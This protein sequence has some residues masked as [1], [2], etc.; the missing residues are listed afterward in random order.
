MTLS[1]EFRSVWPGGSHAGDRPQ[2]RHVLTQKSNTSYDS[3]VLRR[4]VVCEDSRQV[5]LDGLTTIQLAAVESD[6]MAIRI[7]QSSD[8]LRISLVPLRQ[9]VGVERPYGSIVSRRRPYRL[10]VFKPGFHEVAFLNLQSDT[11]AAK[12]AM[13]AM[14][15]MKK[16]DIARIEAAR[17]E[18][19]HAGRSA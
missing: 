17:A 11:A 4:S 13:D 3:E 15:T 1:A 19:V 10:W 18:D 2:Q 5:R 7:E 12:R 14:M 9:D 16:I 6:D 8:A